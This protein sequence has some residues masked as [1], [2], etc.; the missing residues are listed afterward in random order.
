MA[1]SDWLTISVRPGKE[2][3]G[4]M[5]AIE[6]GD[7]LSKNEGRIAALKDRHRYKDAGVSGNG[8]RVCAAERGRRQG[9]VACGCGE[10]GV[11]GEG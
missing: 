8:P 7:P 9:G 1:W 3:A 5:A 10:W 11:R 4:R 2:L 6:T